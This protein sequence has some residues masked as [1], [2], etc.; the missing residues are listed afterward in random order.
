MKTKP[1]IEIDLAQVE[2]LASRGL[3]QAQ[4]A[5]GLGI[6]E[7]T[8]YSRKRENEE[9]RDALKRGKSK[10][11]AKIANTLFEKALEGDN[12]CMIFYL[13]ACGGWSDKPQIEVAV[14]KDQPVQ[15]T[16]INDLK[17]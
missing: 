7:D 2:D 6:S 15:I 9:F 3:T 8:L 12:T 1:K 4:I 5:D 14:E 11:I 10:G 13:K 17:D 16:F